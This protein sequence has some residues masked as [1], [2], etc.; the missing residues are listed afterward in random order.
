MENKKRKR[1][2]KVEKRG[3]REKEG[4]EKRIK[5]RKKEKIENEMNRCTWKKIYIYSE[6]AT[7]GKEL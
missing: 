3:K 7:A 1:E 6:I 2:K 4:V 5:E